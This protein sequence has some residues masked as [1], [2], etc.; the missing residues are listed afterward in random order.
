M[1]SEN[2]S[3]GPQETEG[4]AQAEAP[5][6]TGAPAQAEVTASKSRRGPIIG[7][8]VILALV[9]VGGLVA[10]IAIP[11]QREAERVARMEAEAAAFE[12]AETAY[13]A[14]ESELK[15]A[16]RGMALDARW[17][18]AEE[19]EARA[20]EITAHVESARERIKEA[21]AQIE[22][23]SAS[24]G[25]D[26][27]IDALEKLAEAADGFE[28]ASAELA[29]LFEVQRLVNLGDKA[30]SDADD[31]YDD[32]IEAG[33]RRKYKSMVTISE[34]CLKLFKQAK[35]HYGKAQAAR[36][37]AGISELVDE[38]N[39]R[40]KAAGMQLQMAKYGAAGKINSYNSMIE[41]IE[42]LQDDMYEPA[43]LSKW[44][45]DAMRLETSAASSA[46]AGAE[47]LHTTA[48]ARLED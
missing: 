2:G 19:A 12:K 36:P 24:K 29:Q 14:A 6:Q 42:A 20:A 34:K 22:L 47:R 40:I 9:L 21:Q 5:E 15:E 3:E 25:K 37:G 45:D 23:L 46:L 17:A 8:A 4:P 44:V 27:F 1:V 28:R 30:F 26:E 33:N 7:I 11:A 48:V 10:A 43:D 16:Q 18:K 31:A 35:S 38:T 13:K 41:K 32:A 39:M